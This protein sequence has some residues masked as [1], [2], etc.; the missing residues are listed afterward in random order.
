VIRPTR[1]ECIS[2]NVACPCAAHNL[3]QRVL[4]RYRHVHAGYDKF[5]PEPLTQQIS[6]TAA[7][8]AAQPDSAELSRIV[9]VITAP[10]PTQPNAVESS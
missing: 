1:L 8:S 6:A 7:G 9:R 4:K 5:I 10:D 2:A 3:A